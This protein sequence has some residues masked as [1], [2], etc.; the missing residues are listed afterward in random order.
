M[1]PIKFGA[2]QHRILKYLASV[3]DWS[4]RQQMYAAVGTEKGYSKA[5][6]A[7]TGQH[8]PDSLEARG[9]VDRQGTRPLRYK[10]TSAGQAELHRLEGVA[11]TLGVLKAA[12]LDVRTSDLS[13]AE[14]DTAVELGVVDFPDFVLTGE[15]DVLRR[16]RRG[17]EA[18]RRRTLDNYGMQ[19][20]LCDIRDARLLVASHIERW[21]D[22]VEHRGSLSNA[23]CLCVL[24]DKLFELGYWALDDEL[25]VLLPK[26]LESLTLRRLLPAGLTF[27]RPRRHAPDRSR[28]AQHRRRVMLEG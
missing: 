17:Q 14:L 15:D 16:I 4:T 22:A 1:V 21:A 3:S 13:D 19:C 9:F 28:V 23:I 2:Q 20:A 5:L 10:I 11:P 18:V 7:P 26:E 12:R 24:H 8:H 25:R 27:R 6:G